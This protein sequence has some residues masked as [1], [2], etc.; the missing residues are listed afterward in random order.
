MY[1][2]EYYIF[3]FTVDY[4]Y[5]EWTKPLQS[6]LQKNTIIICYSAR[7]MENYDKPILYD[8]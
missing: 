3:L 4:L 6:L 1:D 8:F 5:L 7:G 2:P